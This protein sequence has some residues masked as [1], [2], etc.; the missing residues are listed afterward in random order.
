MFRASQDSS[1]GPGARLL[2][3]VVVLAA[4]VALAGLISVRADGASSRHERATLSVQ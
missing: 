4:L 3:A 1:S 2:P